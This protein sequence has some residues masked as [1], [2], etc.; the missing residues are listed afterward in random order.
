MTRDKF[1]G[2]TFMTLTYGTRFL[3]SSEFFVVNGTEIALNIPHNCAHFM[4]RETTGKI[5]VYPRNTESE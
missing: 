2:V 5:I 3:R 4:N 1:T